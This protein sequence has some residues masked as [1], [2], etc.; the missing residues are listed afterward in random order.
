LVGNHRYNVGRETPAAAAIADSVSLPGPRSAIARRVAARIA[1]LL[2][3]WP[4]TSR[5]L[6]V[7]WKL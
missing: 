2:V 1:A 7:G 3:E 5:P 4:V 6:H